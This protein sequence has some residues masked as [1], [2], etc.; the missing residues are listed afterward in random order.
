MINKNAYLAPLGLP[1]Q[2]ARIAAAAPTFSELDGS[3]ASASVR[4]VVLAGV[5]LPACRCCSKR[6]KEN[7]PQVKK[8]PH[9]IIH[10]PTMREGKTYPFRSISLASRFGICRC[11]RY[12]MARARRL[13][14]SCTRVSCMDRCCWNWTILRNL[15]PK[16]VCKVYI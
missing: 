9:S 16:K 7:I 3:P 13:S 6:K 5:L 4:G 8:W 10:L 2:T 1:W 11:I 12:R 14:P 15:R